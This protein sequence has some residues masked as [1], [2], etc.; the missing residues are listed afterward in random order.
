M[1]TNDDSGLMH[2]KLQAK[3]LASYLKSADTTIKH[4]NALEAVAKM[5][6]YKDFHTLAASVAGAMANSTHLESVD[7]KFL[8][9]AI[10]VA[11]EKGTNSHLTDESWVGW[12]KVVDAHLGGHEDESLFYAS[13]DSALL[14]ARMAMNCFDVEAMA[15]AMPYID[16]EGSGYAGQIPLAERLHCYLLAVERKLDECKDVEL[17][18]HMKRALSLDGVRYQL[19]GILAWGH[20]E[21]GRYWYAARHA[22]VAAE[23]PVETDDCGLRD[24]A[25]T[26]AVMAGEIGSACEWAA[27]DPELRPVLETAKLIQS[28]CRVVMTD[29]LRAKFSQMLHLAESSM[30]MEDMAKGAIGP[31]MPEGDWGPLM[32]AFA[33][34]PWIA[35]G[36][37]L[38]GIP[39][40]IA[41]V[42]A[43]LQETHPLHPE[44]TGKG[45]RGQ[46]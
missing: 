34:N 46:R 20:F 23:L 2:Y 24:A 35:L 43:A 28:G 26:L 32:D 12:E 29:M 36:R 41:R 9:D 45:V 44:M 16:H 8:R 11:I 31:T 37:W 10:D 4:S 7:S 25:V 33:C 27:D 38:K 42:E 40:L 21:E 3:R 30:S 1:T 17:R 6:G 22:I 15:G 39:D 18:G 5:H 19:L 14:A 13:Q